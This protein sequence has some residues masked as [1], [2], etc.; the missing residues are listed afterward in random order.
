MKELQPGIIGSR[1]DSLLYPLTA[2]NRISYRLSS[3]RST[4]GELSSVIHPE[5]S[6][7]WT[8]GTMTSVRCRESIQWLSS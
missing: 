3:P 1:L 4:L 2:L 6:S 5:G 7:G 8:H